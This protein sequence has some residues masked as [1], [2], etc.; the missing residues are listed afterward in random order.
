MQGQVDPALVQSVAGQAA[1]VPNAEGTVAAS[2]APN[3][4]IA[5]AGGIPVSG[6][7]SEAI[8]GAP[9]RKPKPSHSSF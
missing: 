1:G 4:N 7:I 6:G 3:A 8:T 9:N 5:D 2:S